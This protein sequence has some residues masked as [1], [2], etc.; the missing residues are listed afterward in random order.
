MKKNG[1]T[2]VELLSVLVLIS[3]LMGIAIPG[4]NR[5][6][7]NMKTKS[8]NEK[9]ELIES[10]AVLWGQ[11]N[12]TLLQA[13]NDCKLST[14][15]IVLCYK[16]TVGSLIENSYLDSDNNSGKY[17]NPLDNSDMKN[18]CV[19]IYK[20]NKRVYSYFVGN[21]E[22][23]NFTDEKI[24]K[25]KVIAGD[26]IESGEWHTSDFTLNFEV[27]NGAKT[28]YGFDES[29]VNNEATNYSVN[30]ETKSKIIYVKACKLTNCS[31][32][33]VYEIKLDKNA[34]ILDFQTRKEKTIV[35]LSDSISGVYG[36]YKSE[37]KK[38]KENLLKD[39]FEKIS[40]LTIDLG[41]SS[42]LSY[43]YA[44][45]NAGN[46]KEEHLSNYL[47]KMTFRKIDGSFTKF[48]IVITNNNE[49]YSISKNDIKVQF[50]FDESYGFY[51]NDYGKD[52]NFNNYYS[53]ITFENALKEFKINY[54]YDENYGKKKNMVDVG[55]ITC[56]NNECSFI[57]DMEDQIKTCY[58]DDNCKNRHLGYKAY[59]STGTDNLLRL[60]YYIKIKN[61]KNDFNEIK[62]NA[63]LN[64]F[65]SEKEFDNTWKDIVGSC[66]NSE[67]NYMDD[68]YI[69]YSSYDCSSGRTKQK[70]FIYY[71]MNDNVEIF[72]G[73][74][75]K[76]GIN[77]NGK[78]Y[79][80]K[81]YTY[82]E[83]YIDRKNE[84]EKYVYSNPSNITISNKL[85][86]YVITGATRNNESWSWILI[87]SRQKGSDRIY[88]NQ[89]YFKPEV[90]LIQK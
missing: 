22:C 72:D 67:V 62:L 57:I 42:N 44:L 64:M 78:T 9:K 61:N 53:K 84:W 36:Y 27:D 25:P 46:I 18:Q 74:L 23:V 4:I 54:K 82:L 28:Y 55:D 75:L 59:S 49:N 16:I 88:Y 11:D 87:T 24:K 19:Y 1:F 10:A 26:G 56:R 6:S 5:I 71:V 48:E 69:Y 39:N 45:D 41:N 81:K 86:N 20:K 35:K 17:I 21:K 51:D 14:D 33:A 73:E 29:N 15:E 7:K 52:L 34:P 30:G 37:T 80:Q 43:I 70:R 3:L 40:D 12:K 66:P 47:P 68:Y 83:D 50:E 31:E 63:K 58:S 90:T 77:Y 76:N 60:N 65:I 13:N 89:L 32:N 8:Y 38:E 2:L 85:K 79:L